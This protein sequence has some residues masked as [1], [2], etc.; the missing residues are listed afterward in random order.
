MRAMH[1]Y[2]ESSRRMFPTWSEVLGVVQGLGYRKQAAAREEAGAAEMM[3]RLHAAGWC[4]GDSASE[5][6]DGG[7]LWVVIGRSG[8]HVLRAE[9]ATQVEAWRA[10]LGQ[11]GN[12]VG[13]GTRVRRGA[14][15]VGALE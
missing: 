2:M 5:A 6:E 15:D 4:V 3:A 9:G 14:P 8:N 10:A 13:K 7:H 12:F 11:A 1:E